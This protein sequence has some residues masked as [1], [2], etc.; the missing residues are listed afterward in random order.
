MEIN[1]YPFNVPK[2]EE[3]ISIP[4]T[5]TIVEEKELPKFKI[6]QKNFLIEEKYRF[7][8]TDKLL[9]IGGKKYTSAEL[10]EIAAKIGVPVNKKKLELVKLIKLKIGVE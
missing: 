10:K 8:D 5:N 6:N 1:F 7:I 3:K 9:K 2:F 4:S